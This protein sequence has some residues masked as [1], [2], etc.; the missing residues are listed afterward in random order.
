MMSAALL[1]CGW[2]GL[3]G[4]GGE[5][6]AAYSVPRGDLEAAAPLAL[7]RYWDPAQP[8]PRAGGTA[9]LAW[10]ARYLYVACDFTDRDLRNA[11]E[12]EDGPTHEGDVFE[13]FLM[14]GEDAPHY[15]ELHVT[16]GGVTRD[17]RIARPRTEPYDHYT[18]WDSGLATDVTLA[19]TLNDASDTD[20]GWQAVMRIPWAALLPEGERARAG[21]RWRF[22]VCRYDYTAEA[23]APEHSSTA[24]LRELSFHKTE[25]YDWLVLAPAS[26]APPEEETQP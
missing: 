11:I 4:V 23:A 12:Q 6:P 18:A 2:L 14:R 16:P 1:W 13:V 8:L 21:D 19:G 26:A 3:L 22:A 9:R 20:Q 10:D 15:Y 7:R 17:L 5:T 25:D 24:P